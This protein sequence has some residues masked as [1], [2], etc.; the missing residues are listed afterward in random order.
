M[1]HHCLGGLVVLMS[2]S[3]MLIGKSQDIT[4][5]GSCIFDSESCRAGHEWVKAGHGQDGTGCGHFCCLGL[6]AMVSTL[7][8]TGY[9]MLGNLFLYSGFSSSKGGGEV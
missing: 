8:P 2:T 6:L 9:V 3:G 5:S 7:P 1:H 4:L